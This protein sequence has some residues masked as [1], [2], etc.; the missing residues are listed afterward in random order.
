MNI[1]YPYQQ[2]PLYPYPNVPLDQLIQTSTNIKQTFQQIG[3]Q[4]REQKESWLECMDI[5]NNIFYVNIKTKQLQ[6][7]KPDIFKST[8]ELLLS[9]CQWEVI[10]TEENTKQWKNKQTNEIVSEEPEQYKMIMKRIEEMK[11]SQQQQIEETEDQ[12]KKKKEEIVKILN[13]LN[14]QSNSNWEDLKTKI[15]VSEGIK[16]K[17]VKMIFM[18]MITKLQEEEI[19]KKNQLKKEKRQLIESKLNELFQ[20]ERITVETKC[21][22]V[23]SLLNDLM[24][25]ENETNKEEIKELL[26]IYTEKDINDIWTTIQYK[27]E[28]KKMDEYKIIISNNEKFKN[29]LKMDD[30]IEKCDEIQIPM[31]YRKKL[32]QWYMIENEKRREEEKRRLRELERKQIQLEDE[33]QNVLYSMSRNNELYYK[34]S[35]EK[36]LE[37]VKHIDLNEKIKLELF[38][39]EQDHL[40]NKY[41]D[42]YNDVKRILNRNFGIITPNMSVKTFIS[43]YSLFDRNV[44]RL[45]DYYLDMALKQLYNEDV[46]KMKRSNESNKVDE[47]NLEPVEKKTV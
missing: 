47:N 46:E 32:Y 45:N 3:I 11:Q 25:T 6:Y 26:E 22:E 33:V 5:T 38:E 21:E 39:R 17:E 7:E 43:F 10:I 14:L 36:F 16:M 31:Y 28:K 27:E 13:E 44:C 30:F 35:P 24:N 42:V 29:E 2:I 23:Y 9:T 4:I 40:R 41:L 34:E 18:E 1:P 8:E 15:T 19:I 20:S 12:S 37:R